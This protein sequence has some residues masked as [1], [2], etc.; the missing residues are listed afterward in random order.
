MLW[1]S[2]PGKFYQYL[3]QLVEALSFC[4]IFSD[5]KLCVGALRKE[6]LM[7]P[8][9]ERFKRVALGKP[10]WQILPIIRE[11]LRKHWISAEIWLMEGSVQGASLNELHIPPFKERFKI[12]T[13]GRSCWW[14]LPVLRINSLNVAVLSIFCW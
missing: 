3:E 13:L 9:T 2:L 10:Y 4:W 11:K 8:F 14:I 1:E 5:S 7:A 6:L 12:A